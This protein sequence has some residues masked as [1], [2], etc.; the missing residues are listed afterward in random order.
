M[1]K[2][3]SPVIILLILTTVLMLL[4]LLSVYIFGQ[5]AEIEVIMED[6][7]NIS[8]DYDKNLVELV[9]QNLN[10]N[11]LELNFKSIGKSGKTFV[12]VTSG[13]YASI[14][15][16]Y[17][18]KFGIITVNEFLGRCNGDIMFF[19][20]E[21]LVILAA[22][23]ILAGRYRKSMR[24]SI[25]RY[26][27]IGLLG[28]IIFLGFALVWQL[29]FMV[30]DT[31]Y[32]FQRTSISEIL[33]DM[34]SLGGMFSLVM[35][36]LASLTAIIVTFSNIILLK[37]E[38]KSWRNMLGVFLGAVICFSTVFPFF[39]DSIF[40]LLG[41]EI[42]NEKGLGL[43]FL[44]IFQNCSSMLVA[45]VECLLI[46]TVISGFIAAKHIPA[47]DKD[48]ILILGCQ[49]NKDGS[50]TKLLQSR[51]DRAVE[52]AQM[53]KNN[54]GKDIIFVPSGGQGSDEVM[55]EADAIKNYLLSKGISED[56]ILVENKSVNTFQNITFSKNLINQQKNNA[57]IAFSTTNYHV[58]RAGCIADDE[59]IKIEGIGAKTKS[60]FWINAFIREFIATLYNE[61]RNHLRMITAIILSSL[62]IETLVYISRIM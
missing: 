24:R 2:I 28:L 32:G 33:S 40:N 16:L 61:K 36:P 58:F 15:V 34:K 41:I 49:I 45:Y 52:F 57:N 21:M 35:L 37:R 44:D 27:N 20:S 12:E 47:F 55:P 6:T 17:V 31:Y 39:G 43:A 48:Y 19:L 11:I 22:L 9:S 46:G 53:Q 60:Y 13:E 62:I 5:T 30:Y 54:N 26:A 51:T 23:V 29:F 25:C 42:H 4:S 38:G 56:K 10:D 59:G 8:I 7:Q 14:H 18:H 50:L 1:K 3:K